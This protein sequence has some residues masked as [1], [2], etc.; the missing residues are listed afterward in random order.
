MLNRFSALLILLGVLTAAVSAQEPKTDKAGPITHVA[1]IRLAGATS[2]ISV[3]PVPLLSPGI[4]NFKTLLDRIS[5]AATDKEIHGLVL[6]LDGLELGYAKLEDLRNTIAGFKRSGKKVF[7]YLESGSPA[8][9]LAGCEADHV[10][11]PVS[12]TLMLL[13]TRVDITFYKELFD[14]LDIRAEFIHMGIFKFTGEEYMRANMSKEARAQYNLLL[15]DLYANC[16]VGSIVRSRQAKKDLTPASVRKMID[17]GPYS[18]RQ[19]L[20]LGLVDELSYPADFQEVVRKV[21][22]VKNIKLMRDYGIEK[23]K[24]ELANLIQLGNPT[25]NAPKAPGSNKE[26]IAII[27]AVGPIVTGKGG[28]SF[29]FERQVAAT[30]MIEAIREADKDPKVRGIVLR[31]DSRGGS[32]LASDLI[33]NE[34]KRCKKPVVASMSDYAASGGYY[35]CMGAKKVYA[36]P[37]TITGSIGVVSGKIAFGGLLRKVGVNIETLSRG[38]N[39]GLM[40]RIDTYSSS[41]K[42]ALEAVMR[43][44]Y[45][46]FLDRVAKNRAAAGK[47]FTRQE[48]LDVAEGRIWTGR[49]ALDRGLVDALG[50]LEDAI[51]D[52]KVMGGLTRDA[53]T[54]YLVLPK[55][56]PLFNFTTEEGDPLLGTLSSK[57][58][59]LFGQFPE[60]GEHAGAVEAILQLSAEPVWVMLPHGIRVRW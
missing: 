5:K 3:S 37:G 31:V 44:I 14:K 12:G 56:P 49:Q 1:H 11:M 26:R 42:K 2:E 46:Q 60:F 25:T 35:I 54:D 53:D 43:E 10:V 39:S 9:Y 52:A 40:S 29:F 38:L 48:Q 15:D 47:K 22:G 59:S 21:L 57:T 50:S 45:E 18:A 16:Y 32:S 28:P 19:A 41:E 8:D 33:W 7:A 36:Q 24:F 55:P 27:Y 6:Q 20:E 51:S 58:L 4:G 34:L 13:G 30:T 23:K 17:A